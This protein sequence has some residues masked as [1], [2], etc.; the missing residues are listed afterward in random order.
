VRI[1]WRGALGI[2]LSAGLLVWTLRG[3]PLADVWRELRASNLALFAASTVCA[4]LTFPLRALRWRVILEP[5]APG[6]PVGLLWRATAIGMMVNNVVPA[7]AGELARAFALTKGTARVGFAAAFASIAV[8]RIFDAVVL[9]LLLC[10]AMLDPVFPG[11]AEV[12]GRP[13]AQ[14]LGGWGTVALLAVLASFYAI[15]LFPGRIVSLFE[16][17]A[18]RVAPAVEAKG[19]DAIL[20]F[21]SGLGVLRSPRR[22]GSVF[23]WTA[24]HWLLNALSFWLAFRAVGIMAPFSAALFLQGLIAIGVALP[25]APGFFGV[26]EALARTGLTGVYGVPETLAVSWAIG[27][28]LLTFVPITAMGAFYFARLGM[29]LRDV[30]AVDAGPEPNAGDAPPNAA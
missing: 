12:A 19:R 24:A 1:G 11:G 25:S 28:H 4:T 9:L 27:F 29:H 26:F 22:F 7:R 15:A 2:A 21:A 10:L 18:R 13:V 16:L 8:D 20:T 30:E 6:L 3:V 14:W 23:A 17:F 5:V